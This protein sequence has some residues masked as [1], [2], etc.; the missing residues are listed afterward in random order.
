VA[1][2][3]AAR[4][5]GRSAPAFRREVLHSADPPHRFLSPHQAAVLNAATRRLIPGPDHDPL[6]HGH[7]VAHEAHVVTYVDRLLSLCVADLR[8][9]YTNGI[10]L[11]DRQAGG[12]F[13]AVPPLR[14]DL[15][16]SQRQVASFT[17]LLFGHIAE[18]MYAGRLMPRHVNRCE[19]PPG[20]IAMA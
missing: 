5:Y 10:L 9:R 7:P 16:L 19:D 1:S 4:S 12:D 18:A 17:C 8:D 13:T 20:G 6:G 11:L 2:N 3:E 14:Q 15:I